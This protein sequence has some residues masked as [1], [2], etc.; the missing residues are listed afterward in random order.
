[1]GQQN[2]KELNSTTKDRRGLKGVIYQENSDGLARWDHPRSAR[3]GP[4]TLLVLDIYP[5][6]LVVLQNRDHHREMSP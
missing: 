6:K 4:R 2:T 3:W 5:I 1:M